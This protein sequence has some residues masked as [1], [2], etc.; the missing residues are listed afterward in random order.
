MSKPYYLGPANA[1]IIY[2]SIQLS[3]ASLHA[4]NFD[5]AAVFENFKTNTLISHFSFSD[6]EFLNQDLNQDASLQAF[7][8]SVNRLKE[9]HCKD[10]LYEPG[11]AHF[12]LIDIETKFKYFISQQKRVFD[13]TFS[14]T[15]ALCDRIWALYE[16]EL[17]AS[18]QPIVHFSTQIN[19]NNLF[20]YAM[21]FYVQ[22][23]IGKKNQPYIK[24]QTGRAQL[25]AEAN[26]LAPATKENMTHMLANNVAQQGK[27][28]PFTVTCPVPVSYI[29]DMDPGLCQCTAYFA[30][31]FFLHQKR[32]KHKKQVLKAAFETGI[33]LRYISIVDD[34]YDRVI[35]ISDK[36]RKKLNKKQQHWAKN[37]LANVEQN[38][39][40]ANEKRSTS[41]DDDLDNATET[42]PLL[43][44]MSRTFYS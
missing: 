36:D 30:Y 43:P 39:L 40:T 19:P 25:P 2:Y 21:S 13:R 7:I 27:L 20:V 18:Y 11:V 16:Q 5:L 15:L 17:Q 14:S 32:K 3:L 23:L 12:L 42:T 24:L 4:A 35:T 8:N 34:P 41:A 26:R 29:A 9:L 31:Q 6:N 33:P 38:F 44:S 10:F 28:L 1:A 37:Y 22:K